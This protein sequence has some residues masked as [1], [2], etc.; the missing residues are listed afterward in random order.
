MTYP[1]TIM[2]ILENCCDKSKF[3][4][5]LSFYFVYIKF[6]ENFHLSLLF[7]K[8]NH[9]NYLVFYGRNMPPYKSYITLNANF[10]CNY[11]R[12]MGP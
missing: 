11:H 5:N 9:D 7:S 6:P 8:N 1:I 10:V 3:P 12:K 2:I 4:Q